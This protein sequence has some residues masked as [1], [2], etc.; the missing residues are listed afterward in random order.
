MHR[1]LYGPDSH[2]SSTTSTKFR[3]ICDRRHR[4]LIGATRADAASLD[5]RKC[6]EPVTP[7]SGFPIDLRRSG[8]RSGNHQPPELP[9]RCTR[10]S[11]GSQC[12]RQVSSS[13]NSCNLR[14][15]RISHQISME[16]RRGRARRRGNPGTV[17]LREKENAPRRWLPRP[18]SQLTSGEPAATRE[19]FNLRRS[20]LGAITTLEARIGSVK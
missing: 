14:T 15:N 11:R 7:S 20:Y 9:A 2:R 13:A 18:A 6:T 4:R 3:A 8:C 10:E 19:A 16:V 12:R 5:Q 1:G 17:F